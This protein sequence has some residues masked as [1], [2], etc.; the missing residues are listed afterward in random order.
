MKSAGSELRDFVIDVPAKT[1]IQ[2][3]KNHDAN[4]IEHSALLTTI[5]PMMKTTIEAIT[6]ADLNDHVKIL[7]KASPVKN[8]LIIESKPTVIHDMPV[9]P[10]ILKNHYSSKL[11]GVD[12]F[13]F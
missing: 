2:A 12:T 13:T 3:I 8:T 5:M 1:F 7:V 6:E 9:L 10:Q 4:L 11:A